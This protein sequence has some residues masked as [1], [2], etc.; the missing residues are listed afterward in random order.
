LNCNSNRSKR[1]D[2]SKKLSKREAS[3]VVRR[4]ENRYICV[5]EKNS[6]KRVSIFFEKGYNH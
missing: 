1:Q 4:I 3:H 5:K 6:V 2:I